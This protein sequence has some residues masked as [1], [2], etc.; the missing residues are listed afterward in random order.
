MRIGLSELRESST[1][2]TTKRRSDED[3]QDDR[4]YGAAIFGS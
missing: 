3:M 1:S 4:P 2:T